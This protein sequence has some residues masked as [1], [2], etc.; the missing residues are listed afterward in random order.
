MTGHN[1]LEN[2]IDNPEALPRKNRSRT[3]SSSVTLAAVEPVTPVT[4]ATT[5]MAQKSLREFSVP[6]IANGH[7][8]QHG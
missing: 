4:S 1:L 3:A 6:A 2:Y 5:A 7:R 8:R